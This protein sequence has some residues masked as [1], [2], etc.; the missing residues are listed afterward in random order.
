MTFDEIV[1]LFP[2][3]FRNLRKLPDG[4]A[5]WIGKFIYTYP[6]CIGRV[7]DDGNYDDRWC[8]ENFDKA[9]VALSAWNPMT[10]SEPEGWIRHPKSGR[11]RPDA[12]KEKEYVNL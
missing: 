1:E 5:V 8:Y 7:S 10:S 3:Q 2:Y 6:I 12:N 4:R 11:R 9:A